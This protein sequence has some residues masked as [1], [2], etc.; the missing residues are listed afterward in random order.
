MNVLLTA[1]LDF[2]G[3]LKAIHR[4]VTER[5]QDFVIRRTLDQYWESIHISQMGT[6]GG[7]EITT[8]STLLN[9]SLAPQQQR[10]S[11]HRL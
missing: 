3:R 8:D 5:W 6:A 2:R 11:D 9:I 1:A 4:D 7:G 10:H